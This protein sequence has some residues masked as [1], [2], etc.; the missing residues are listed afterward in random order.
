MLCPQ[1]AP[2]GEIIESLSND[3][4]D[5]KKN[6]KKAMGLDWHNN[7][8]ARRSRYL[9]IS[10]PPLHDYDVRRPIF[11]F[12]W[13]HK[14]TKG[15]SDPLFFHV[16]VTESEINTFT[17]C[18]NIF[19]QFSYISI[20]NYFV[21]ETDWV[22]GKPCRSFLNISFQKLRAIKGPQGKYWLGNFFLPVIKFN[23]Y[24]ETKTPVSNC[25]AV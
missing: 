11:L 8:F 17:F 19:G 14:H 24:F 10:L 12:Y 5:S 3:D 15:M 20:L 13:G 4:G 1:F 6:G 25:L 21:K 7:N 23:F 22:E 2:S 9:Y 18:T 16:F